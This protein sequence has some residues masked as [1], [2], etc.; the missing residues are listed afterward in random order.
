M[1]GMTRT[2]RSLALSAGLAF[3]VLEPI[4]AQAQTDAPAAKPAYF[5]AEYEVIDRE[6]MKPYSAQV[7]STFEPYGGRFV[8]RGGAVTSLEGEPVKGGLVVIAFGSVEKAK[9]WYESPAYGKIRPLR[10]KSARTRV[11]IV[12]GA[13]P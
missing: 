11:Y 6:G 3:G 7:Q 10:W 9:A 1:A 2:I 5:V 12:E 8:V 13:A 4:A